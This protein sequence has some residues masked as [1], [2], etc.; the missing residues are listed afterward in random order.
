MK[1][2]AEEFNGLYKTKQEKEVVLQKMTKEEIDHLIIT[3]PNIYGKIFY[4]KFKKKAGESVGK[5]MKLHEPD[6]S[7]EMQK[8]NSLQFEL[9]LWNRVE[10]IDPNSQGMDFSNAEYTDDVLFPSIKV[11]GFNALNGFKEEFELPCYIFLDDMSRSDWREE[12]E[13][14][15]DSPAAKNPL[16]VM[17]F[18]KD[19]IYS[20]KNQLLSLGYNPD[21][22]LICEG[23]TGD[24]IPDKAVILTYDSKP[25]ISVEEMKQVIES[26]ASTQELVDAYAT[27]CNMVAFCEDEI[28]DHEEGS[29][30]YESASA[31][32]DLWRD[33]MDNLETRIIKAATDEGLITE[34][35]SAKGIVKEI[36]RFMDKY[37]YH[38]GSGWWIKKEC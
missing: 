8:I 3:C 16:E 23:S 30:E 22:L 37:G 35:S 25:V 19:H 7:L 12:Y 24:E 36:E 14:S 6:D 5:Q 2:T 1:I 17:M 20:L 28:Y 26:I 27:S 33:M 9:S 4:S 10:M 29:E 34:E 31:L 11:S 18:V 32:T 13:K 21:D 38:E 15:G